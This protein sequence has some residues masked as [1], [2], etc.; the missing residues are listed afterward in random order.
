MTR[1][2]DPRDTVD[3]ATTYVMRSETEHINS[4]VQGVNFG[5]EGYVEELVKEKDRL[6]P[7]GKFDHE[8]VFIATGFY[9]TGCKKR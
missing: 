8:E 2:F 4:I 3:N 7:K 9:L 1:E 6:S 5:L